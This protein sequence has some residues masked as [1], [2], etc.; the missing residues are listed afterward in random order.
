MLCAGGEDKDA[1]Q[2][3]SGGPLVCREDSGESC[4]AGI[5]SWGVG[6]AKEGVPGV[7]TNV[8]KYNKWIQD[9]MAGKLFVSLDGFVS[10]LVDT[11]SAVLIV[12]PDF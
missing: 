11:P 2:G 7:Y 4:L 10:I 6:C 8:R 3:D 5:V 1:C 12:S 9:H